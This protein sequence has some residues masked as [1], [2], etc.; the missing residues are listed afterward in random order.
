MPVIQPL[1]S[2]VLPVAAEALGPVLVGY[3]TGQGPGARGVVLLVPFEYP[4]LLEAHFAG[5]PVTQRHTNES[6]VTVD[7]GPGHGIA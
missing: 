5:R 4:Q 1:L 2:Q 3:P 6:A 7:A